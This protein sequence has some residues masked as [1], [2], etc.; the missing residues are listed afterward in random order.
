MGAAGQPQPKRQHRAFGK[1]LGGL[2]ED[3]A[4]RDVDGIG[5]VT[6]APAEAGHLTTERHS[7]LF[8]V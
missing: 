6:L 1:P 5:V 3:A 7:G 4:N 8:S 2:E